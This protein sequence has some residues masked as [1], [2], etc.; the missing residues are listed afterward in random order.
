M[1]ISRMF[2]QKQIRGRAILGLFLF[3]SGCDWV[4]SDFDHDPDKV[5][6]DEI[7]SLTRTG[8]GALPA[9]GTA[10]DTFFARIPHD[11]STRQVTFST[12]AGTFELTNAKEVKIR[13]ER[14]AADPEGPLVAKAVLRADTLPSTAIVSALVSEFRDTLWVPMIK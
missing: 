2:S 7:I 12:T 8:T 3:A 5:P 10:R 14:N 13:A 6:L 9:Y 11:A 1:L 4:A